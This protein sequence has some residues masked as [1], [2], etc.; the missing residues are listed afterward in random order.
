[1]ESDA[2]QLPEDSREVQP[3]AFKFYLPESGKHAV[4]L[5]CSF[6]EAVAKCREAHSY[7]SI[8]LSCV[9]PS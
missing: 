6:Q 7:E 5:G 9:Q 3:L 1:M 2:V 8:S 4:V